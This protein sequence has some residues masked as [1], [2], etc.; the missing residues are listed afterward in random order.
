M[1]TL[2]ELKEMRNNWLNNFEGETLETFKTY[3]FVSYNYENNRVKCTND[4]A[5]ARSYA[6]QGGQ[7]L[8][9]KNDKIYTFKIKTDEEY[10]EYIANQVKYENL[11]QRNMWG[12]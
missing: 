8:N 12:L 11:N 5:E 10:L 3:N 9:L 6:E 7:V 2:E 1:K 4:Y